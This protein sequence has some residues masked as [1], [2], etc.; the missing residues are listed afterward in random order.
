MTLV[1]FTQ[2]VQPPPPQC[3]H[4]HSNMYLVSRDADHE[5]WRCI[6]CQ[7]E[8]HQEEQSARPQQT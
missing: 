3:I 1:Q 2:P 8:P 7:P 4:C 6:N 5:T